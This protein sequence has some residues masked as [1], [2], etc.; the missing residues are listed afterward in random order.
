VRQVTPSGEYK[1]SIIANKPPVVWCP[2][3]TDL[4]DF[5]LMGFQTC[6]AVAFPFALAGLFL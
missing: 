2:L 5:V 3:A 1:E 4:L 6:T